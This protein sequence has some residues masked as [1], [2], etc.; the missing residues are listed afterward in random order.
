MKNIIILLAY[1]SLLSGC[2]DF[3]ESLDFT[4]VINPNLSESSV[5]GQ[6]NSAQIW[7]AGIERE[8]SR[9]LNEILIL[10]ELGSDNYANTQTFYSQ[11]LDNLDIRTTDPD[12]RDTQNE[13]ARIAK[14][15]EFGLSSVGPGDPEYTQEVEAEYHFYLGLSRLYAA[16]YFSELSQETLGVPQNSSSNYDSAIASFNSAIGIVSKP[17]YH[18]ALARAHYYLGNKD[19]AVKAAGDAITLDSD[20]IRSAR[21]DE[22][23]EPSNTM[24]SALYE[25]GTFDD[26]Q[27]L[28]TLDF[29]DPKYSFL[30]PDVDPSVHIL[31]AEEAYLILA[32]ASHAN[33]DL[34]GMKSNLISLFDV[35]ASREIRII[36]DSGETRGDQENAVDDDI[37]PSGS[38]DTVNGRSGLVLDRTSGDVSI[39]SVSGTSL[40]ADEISSMEINDK[41][42]ELVY[43]TRQEVF[44]AEGLR[45][46]DMGVKLVIN[47][48]EILQNDNIKDGDPGT[49][50]V[51]PTFI[52]S[53]KNDLDAFT[54][55]KENGIAT[56]K[57]NINEILVANKN[58]EQVLPFH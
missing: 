11:F 28:P 47:E 42:L 52:D 51:I 9:T 17:E 32:E 44:I 35:I 6:P 31:K 38:D 5:V 30:T 36:D 25:R 49:I 41:S 54:Y 21:F 56:T 3:A 39:P 7:K 48:N 24:E 57:I 1:L 16:M 8:I 13:I 27:P 34:S 55:D 58:S 2:K 19:E 37:R 33:N 10:A 53:V 18:L 26:F 23:E 50:P 40:T 12:I 29:L 45:F 14:M 46:V 4:E 15:A 20:F 43:Q 22:K